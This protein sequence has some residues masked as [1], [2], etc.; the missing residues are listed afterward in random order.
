MAE[1][2]EDEVSDLEDEEE[3]DVEKLSPSKKIV[4]EK[5]T[6]STPAPSAR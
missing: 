4:L 1:K 3:M 5:K 6:N 2:G